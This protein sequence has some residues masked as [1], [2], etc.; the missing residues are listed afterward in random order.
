MVRVPKRE[1]TSWSAGKAVAD[2][3]HRHAH[4]IVRLHGD[5]PK[6]ASHTDGCG[7]S[8]RYRPCEARRSRAMTDDLDPL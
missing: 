6:V 2:I 1:F 7:L 8:M 3:A 5:V 4:R